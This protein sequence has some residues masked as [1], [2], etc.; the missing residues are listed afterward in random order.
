MRRVIIGLVVL[1]LVVLSLFVGYHAFSQSQA[2]SQIEVAGT[3]LTYTLTT[4]NS[5]TQTLSEISIAGVTLSVELA[6]TP[7]AQAQG[8]SDRDSMPADHGMLFVFNQEA[9]WAFWMHEMRFSLDIIWFNSNRQAVFIEQDLPPCTPAGCPVYTPTA[10]AT[11]V[12][13]VNAGFVRANGLALG[14]SFSFV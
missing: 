1:V 9:E 10:N 14:D 13:E 4:S 12:L 8:L 7:A 6:T 3:T 5:T 2:T 11:Y